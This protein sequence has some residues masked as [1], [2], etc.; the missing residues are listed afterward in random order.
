MNDRR[1]S[2][3]IGKRLHTLWESFYSLVYCFFIDIARF[4]KSLHHKI[5]QRKEKQHKQQTWQHQHTAQWAKPYHSTTSFCRPI[6][7]E[8]DPYDREFEFRLLRAR[9]EPMEL[10]EFCDDAH[11]EALIKSGTGESVYKVTEQSCE[12]EDFRKRKKPCKHM[13]FFAIKTGKFLQYEVGPYERRH[14]GTNREGRF[15]PRYWEYYA[16]APLWLGYNNLCTF[17]VEGRVYGV[18]EKT[19]RKTN[20]KCTTVVNAINEQ[21]AE[22]A[23]AEA[24]VMPPYARIER[25][26]V[27]PTY[28]QYEFLHAVD[29]PAPYFINAED[30]SALLTRYEDQDDS[31]C[32]RFLFEMATRYRVCVSYFR[33]ASYVKSCIWAAIPQEKRAA[34][35]CYAVHCKETGREF[36]GGTVRMENKVFSEFQPTEKEMEYIQNIQEFGWRPPHGN[37]SAYK[38]AVA[39]LKERNML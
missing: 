39:F 30:I 38:S 6:P 27:S 8:R 1:R 12:C 4:G 32:P 28:R 7:E 3:S 5:L 24:G 21:E 36:G 14:D 2:S 20:R 16:G 11:N 9:T 33:P 22:K 25:I 29:I 37:A 23:A 19:G 34:A 10:L 31:R 18:S 26:D 35:F 17:R 13:I 15:V